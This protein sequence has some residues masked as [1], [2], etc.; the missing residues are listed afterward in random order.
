MRMFVEKS[1]KCFVGGRVEAR[2][3]ENFMVPPDLLSTSSTK[4]T[5]T[6]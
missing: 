4:P 3:G 1:A 2:S 5:D 6:E